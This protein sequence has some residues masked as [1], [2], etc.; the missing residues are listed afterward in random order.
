MVKHIILFT[1]SPDADK[2]SVIANAEKAL[3]P[4]V[5]KIPGLL[6]MEVRKAFSGPDFVLYSEF[7]SPEALAVYADH[8]LHLEAKSHFFPQITGRI[9]ADYVV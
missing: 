6:T 2:D 3:M 7:E 1:V 8:P 9:A 4:L 5:G